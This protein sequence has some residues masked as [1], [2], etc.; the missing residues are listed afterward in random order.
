MSDIGLTT[1]SFFGERIVKIET[2]LDHHDDNIDNMERAIENA[3]GKAAESRKY[4]YEKIEKSD[5]AHTDEIQELKALINR[6][7]IG[8]LVG[9]IGI[10][11]NVI[12]TFYKL[13]S[14][15]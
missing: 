3:L 1:Q 2:R 13:K 4:I 5:K 12:L 10:L 15:V 8:G 11:I 7:I 6:I 9:L 14:G